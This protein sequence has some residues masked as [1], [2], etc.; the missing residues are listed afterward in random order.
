[1]TPP[2]WAAII[3]LE[4]A[5][6][7]GLGAFALQPTSP[8]SMEGSPG[9]LLYLAHCASCHGANLE[10]EPRW[11]VRRDD[12]RLPA[13]PHDASGHTCITPT[14]RCFASP[15]KASPPSFPATTRICLLSAKRS[16]T[17]KSA[18]FSNSSRARGRNA[19]ASIS[20]HGSREV[21]VAITVAQSENSCVPRDGNRSHA[22]GAAAAGA[23]PSPASEHVEV[24]HV[25]LR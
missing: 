11:K 3:G 22:G 18:R 14:T 9:H 19:S 8:V 1:M 24:E 10:G 12:G 15:R 13:P 23:T 17:T 4:A 21:A 20:R 6:L 2:F 25:I 7:A 16:L 5:A